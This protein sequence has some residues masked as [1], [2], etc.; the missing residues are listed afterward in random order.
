MAFKRKFGRLKPAQMSAMK[1][2]EESNY[3]V[4][5][6]IMDETSFGTHQRKLPEEIITF[7]QKS[8]GYH[9][10][11]GHFLPLKKYNEIVEQ[12]KEFPFKIKEI[13]NEVLKYFEDEI[14][15]TNSTNVN[16]SNNMNNSNN[17]NRFNKTNNK[18]P[19]K[20][21]N[22]IGMLKFVTR[23]KSNNSLNTCD[24][25]NE[26]D[27]DESY[28][29]S[30]IFKTDVL[31]FLP[32][33]LKNKLKPFQLEGVRF[34]IEHNGKCLI[35]DEMG[36]G[37]TLQ[38]ISIALNY[39]DEWPLLIIC[40]SSLRQNW[41]NEITQ[42][43]PN[44]SEMGGVVVIFGSK[45]LTKP[46]GKVTILS[47][48]IASK[49]AHL[50]LQ[51]KFKIVIADECHYL[52][53]SQS[54]RCRELLP[55]FLNA[56]HTILMSGTA[57]LSRP[58][59]LYP[60]LQALQFPI[61]NTFHQFAIR[62]CKATVTPFGWDYNGN[63]HLSELH[64]LL[65]KYV[66][67]RRL[68]E[69]VLTELPDKERMEVSI[70]ISEED[71]QK[72][73]DLRLAM[74]IQK[75]KIDKYSTVGESSDKNVFEKFAKQA[76]FIELYT[77]TC[78][79]KIKGVCEFLTKMVL[80][81]KKLL[82]FGHHQEM[83]DGIQQ[84]VEENEIEFIRIDGSTNP[85]MR[86]KY[87]NSFQKERRI[88]I[89]ILS[90]TAAGTGITL[91][92][93]D[94]VVFA[95][96]YWTPGV[97]RQAEDRVHRIGQKND[98]RIF[99]LLAKNSI[100]DLIWPLLEKKLKISGETLDGKEVGHDSKKVDVNVIVD[101]MEEEEDEI[102]DDF[103]M[104][105]NDNDCITIDDDDDFNDTNYSDY[106]LNN[107][108][109]ISREIS[110]EFSLNESNGESIKRDKS[111]SCRI[112]EL[113]DSSEIL[114]ENIFEEVPRRKTKTIIT[115]VPTT[116]KRKSRKSSKNELIEI[117]EINENTNEK[118][119][120]TKSIKTVKLREE[121]GKPVALLQQK[122]KR[123]KTL[124]DFFKVTHPIPRSLKQFAESS[125]FFDSPKKG[126]RD[127]NDLTSI[128]N[129]PSSIFSSSIMNDTNSQNNLNNDVNILS[130]NN[131]N[132]NNNLNNNDTM[133]TNSLLSLIGSEIHSTITTNDVLDNNK[134]NSFS[135]TKS[136]ETKKP[137]L[138]IHD[139]EIEKSKDKSSNEINKKKSFKNDILFQDVDEIL[140]KHKK[141]LD[142]LSELNSKD[143]E[144]IEI[145]DSEDNY[146]NDF[147]N[148]IEPKDDEQNE[149]KMNSFDNDIDY[150]YEMKYQQRDPFNY[151]IEN[152]QEDSN[153]MKISRN[154]SKSVKDNQNE[155]KEEKKINAI[156]PNRFIELSKHQREV[157]GT[158]MTE[159]P[160]EQ[161]KRKKNQN[162]KLDFFFHISKRNSTNEI[163]NEDEMKLSKSIKTTKTAKD[164]K[165]EMKESKE[166]KTTSEAKT[167]QSR[168]VT[169]RKLSIKE[170]K[171][172]KK[173]RNDTK[174]VLPIFKPKISSTNN[175]H[176]DDEIDLEPSEFE[177]SMR[178]LHLSKKS[179]PKMK[180]NTLR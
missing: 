178:H 64:V 84:F 93:A 2:E 73:K 174:G 169:K 6:E 131:M 171:E 98:V 162:T 167:K 155:M 50:L 81:G 60:Q 117:K 154:N 44:I 77:M 17:S 147:N 80:E 165:N 148:N 177:G 157:L 138:S 4:I 173:I 86:Q 43:V 125:S 180:L 107:S 90:I 136:N 40:P 151:E 56:E 33:K 14:N 159:T 168:K 91:H 170:I 16:N 122:T 127:E 26:F 118:N 62:Y 29:N 139:K 152:I 8:S 142:T 37:K 68:K 153:E 112:M 110:R 59:E 99:Y 97:L 144:V 179:Q 108:T 83:L 52:K 65:S 128:D 87:V 161:Q 70:S 134:I 9:K 115:E 45:D 67:I 76:Q 160:E 141:Q 135:L 149:I 10:N 175:N 66:M 143:I 101:R 88:K 27:E 137:K 72:M 49:H 111:K 35:A 89:A 47:Y 36:L 106:S 42:N 5:L 28:I 132:N 15:G 13:P 21:E 120:T 114:D 12:L 102:E 69:D 104:K 32:M 163:E 61:F 130:N 156:V 176:S 39:K 105:E 19:K 75:K 95:E 57:L 113:E 119:D 94:T 38:S 116:K 55:V 71:V 96:L 164:K 92:S 150:D 145:D 48:E 158:S 54:K 82:V 20:N 166:K 123:E 11:N 58:C 1:K 3:D 109:N 41:Q 121:N 7:F 22:K 63:S 25:E 30:E 23:S 133:T 53:N 78:S 18:T 129:F 100:D 85:T 79:A 103:M 74:E 126:K 124:D 34:G 140:D 31:D 24:Y 51:K 172:E 46:W 146:L